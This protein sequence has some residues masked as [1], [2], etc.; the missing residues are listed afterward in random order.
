MR[1]KNE[2]WV[3]VAL[4]PGRTLGDSDC[5]GR[6]GHAMIE[7]H[8]REARTWNLGQLGPLHQLIPELAATEPTARVRPELPLK[9][10][11]TGGEIGRR[12]GFRFRRRKA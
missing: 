2:R 11:R 10:H 3:T 1:P 8:R 6:D 12:S 7:R 5:T 9:I 4:A